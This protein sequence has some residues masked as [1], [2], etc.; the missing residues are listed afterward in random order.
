MFSLA[1][2]WGG[3][4]LDPFSG[5]GTTGLVA[6]E[7]GR[8]YVGIEL[9]PDYAEMSRKRLAAADPICRQERMFA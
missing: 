3:A 1:A 8:S 4:I 2:L 7:H 5:A 9:N 6:L